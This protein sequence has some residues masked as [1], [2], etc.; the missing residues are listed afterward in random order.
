M[1]VAL[2]VS[3]AE[4]SRGNFLVLFFYGIDPL[5]L[6]RAPAIGHKKARS[7]MAGIRVFLGKRPVNPPCL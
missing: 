7:N 4:K 1:Q 2:Q 5:F 3:G 6:G